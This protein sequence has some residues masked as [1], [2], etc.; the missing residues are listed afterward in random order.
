MKQ[1]QKRKRDDDDTSEEDINHN[2]KKILKRYAKDHDT[3]GCVAYEPVIPDNETFES[4]ESKK[5]VLINLFKE[6][7]TND[8]NINQILN[9]T[10][11]SQRMC[12]NRREAT[13]LTLKEV[14]EN[15]WPHLID[16]NTFFLMQTF[17]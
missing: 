17:F 2:R 5:N 10:Y 9:D 7:E 12:I 6:D 1:S 11:A 4:Q 8:T 3:Y 13:C 14:L 16:S 15:H